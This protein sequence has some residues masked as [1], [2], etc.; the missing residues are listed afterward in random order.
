MAAEN[1]LESSLYESPQKLKVSIVSHISY[2]LLRNMKRLPV[3]LLTI[4]LDYVSAK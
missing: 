2:R 1:A 4:Y 3:A